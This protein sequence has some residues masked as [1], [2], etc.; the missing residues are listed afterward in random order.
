[1]GLGVGVGGG[2][3]DYYIP[4]RFSEIVHFCNSNSNPELTFL[5]DSKLMI[6]KKKLN[7]KIYSFFTIRTQIQN[8]N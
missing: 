7:V 4:P 8:S 5:F 3:T 2:I 6:M 1:M